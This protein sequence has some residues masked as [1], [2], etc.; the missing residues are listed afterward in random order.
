MTQ[1][2]NSMELRT[3]NMGVISNG[4]T[5]LDAGALDNG[6]AT[7]AMTLIKTLTA[8]NSSTL[9][10]V[11]G[12]SS[13]VFDGTYKSYVIKCIDIHPGNDDVY[14]QMNVSIDS[15][16]NY[17]VSKNTTSWRSSNDEDGSAAQSDDEVVEYRTANDLANGTGVQRLTEPLGNQN[18]ES[19]SVCI[20]IFNPADTTYVKHFLATSVSNTYEQKS[21]AYWVAGYVNSTSAV[22]AIQFSC[23]AGSISTGTIKLYGIK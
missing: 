21:Q 2:S 17:N 20:Q 3:V 6:I 4:T 15:G 10:L 7:G 1:Q 19:C 13:V 14:F 18:Q 5:L 11:H 22:N 16:S 12:S 23:S 9:S 8:S